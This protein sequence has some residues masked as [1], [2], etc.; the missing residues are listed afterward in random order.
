MR[1]TT[2][3]VVTLAL[4]LF[5]TAGYTADSEPESDSR[6]QSTALRDAREAIGQGE[7]QRAVDLLLDANSS[8]PDDADTLNLLGY[9]YRSTGNY[10]DALRYYEQALAIDPEHKGVN[11]YIG[12]LFLQTDKLDKAEHH[13]RVL[14]DVCASSCD[15][16]GQLKA[17]IEAYKKRQSS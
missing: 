10:T 7:Y 3:A 13:L 11:E 16:Y 8:K 9:S 14:S 15:E 6:T 1:H 5:A 12:E 17:S 2:L 4:S